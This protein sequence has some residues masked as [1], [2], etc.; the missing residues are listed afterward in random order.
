MTK[1]NSP[2]KLAGSSIAEPQSHVVS[3]CFG[4]R[5]VRHIFEEN[6]LGF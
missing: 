5:H 6:A 2:P 3:G 1:P 4:G